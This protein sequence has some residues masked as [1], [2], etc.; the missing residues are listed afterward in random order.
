MLKDECIMKINITLSENY[1]FEV[2]EK[3]IVFL[4]DNIVILGG[5]PSA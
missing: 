3:I 5:K 2:V 4:K 1:A